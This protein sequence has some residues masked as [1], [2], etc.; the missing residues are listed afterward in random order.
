MPLFYIG[1]V[2]ALILISLGSFSVNNDVSI[3]LLSSI[4]DGLI[5]QIIDWLIVQI[6]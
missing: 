6:G 1:N 2:A 4:T 3:Q 5:Q